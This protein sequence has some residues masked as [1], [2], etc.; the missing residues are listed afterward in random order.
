M[1]RRT[2]RRPFSVTVVAIGPATAACAGAEPGTSTARSDTAAAAD[3]ATVTSLP[4]A[5]FATILADD[6][7]LVINVH[8]P[9]EGSIPGTDAAI[10]FDEVRGRSTDLPQDLG[11]PVAVYCKS[12]RM[13][14]QA[15]DALRDLGYTDVVEL[16]GG[17]DARAADGRELLLAAG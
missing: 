4:P 8:V 7:V 14:A 9:D 17:M 10:P 1:S 6:D 12:G 15:V 13:S 5:A 2:S 16:R 3:A 11:T